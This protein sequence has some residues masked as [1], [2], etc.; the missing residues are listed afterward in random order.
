M[1][2]GRRRRWWLA[3]LVVVPLLA[4]VAL[5]WALQPERLGALILARAE[6]T[7]GLA[8][9]VA[10][11]ARLGLWPRLQLE[12]VGLA[13]RDPAGRIVL[14]AERVDVALPLRLL[15]SHD[16]DALEIG[17]LH[18][19][20]PQLDLGAAGDWLDAQSDAPATR[21]QLPRNAVALTIERGRLDGPGWQVA[22]LE[23]TA[24]PLRAEQPFVATVSL[25]LQLDQ[26][27]PLPL[28]AEIAL[29][30]RDDGNRIVLDPLHLQLGAEAGERTLAIDGDARMSSAQAHAADLAVAVAADW[31][32]AWPT[33]PALLADRLFGREYR[34]GYRRA[35]DH[36]AALTI[37][38][39]TDA[40]QFAIDVDPALLLA[41]LRDPARPPLPAASAS[42]EASN[43]SI[44]GIEID[45]LGIELQPADSDEGT[46]P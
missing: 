30:P 44:D 21:W 7:L 9:T 41:W 35:I 17:E 27:D 18:L 2:V 23:L 45:G 22:G 43:W 36:P 24:D 14:Q 4:F 39:R 3:A 6:A 5:R 26:R 13:A 10:E 20:A 15:W 29:H 25:T 38:S 11:P 40:D 8:L 32:R 12:L 1:A 37:R 16:E 34:L 31:P 33:P 42:F 28:H 46:T 19:R